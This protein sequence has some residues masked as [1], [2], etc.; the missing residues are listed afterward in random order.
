[1][2]VVHLP[3]CLSYMH[4]GNFCSAGEPAAGKVVSCLCPQYFL[5]FPLLHGVGEAPLLP[6]GQPL[7]GPGDCLPPHLWFCCQ[8][9]CQT[10]QCVSLRG[11]PT[12]HCSLSRLCLGPQRKRHL[13]LWFTAP[14]PWPQKLCSLI[15]HMKISA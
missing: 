13:L 1:M 8:A 2:W 15:F 3:M 12:S 14:P 10:C 11:C 7:P 4:S 5:L 9:S 6:S